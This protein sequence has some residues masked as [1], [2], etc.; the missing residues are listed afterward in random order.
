M[1]AWRYSGFSVPNP[2]AASAEIVSEFTQR[3]KASWARFIRKG[4][5]AD[6]LQ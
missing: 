4:Y 2:C 3:A 6:P 1:H 5:E